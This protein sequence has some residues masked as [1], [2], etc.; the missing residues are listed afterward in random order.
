MYRGPQR[1]IDL[2]SLERDA[3][4]RIL[5]VR[6]KPCGHRL[7]YQRRQT[8]LRSPS[9]ACPGCAGAAPAP[10]AAAPAPPRPAPAAAAAA[11]GPRRP[12]PHVIPVGFGIDE[13]ALRT[14][15]RERLE[16]LRGRQLSQGERDALLAGELIFRTKP[17]TVDHSQ[18][19]ERFERAL[20]LAGRLGGA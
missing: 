3:E 1:T 4:G 19:L 6:L 7:V 16:D 17:G 13:V 15:D 12:P 2:G 10:R 14:R 11:R 9:T 8:N 18:A 20:R 5:A